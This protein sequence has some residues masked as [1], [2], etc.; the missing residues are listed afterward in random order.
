MKIALCIILF[1][2]L[3]PLGLYLRAWA[4]GSGRGSTPPPPSFFL[5][6]WREDTSG[7]RLEWRLRCEERAI[8]RA[9]RR[10]LRRERKGKKQ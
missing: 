7:M 4:Y 1:L 8:N 5:R 10:K 3:L 9:H 2:L 6:R